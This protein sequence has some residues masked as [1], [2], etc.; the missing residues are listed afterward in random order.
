METTKAKINSDK[1]NK[2]NSISDMKLNRRKEWRLELPLKAVVEGTLPDGEKFI[3][4]TM[5]ENISSTGAYFFLNSIITI[6][7][8]LDLF[9][10][11]PSKMTEGKKLRLYLGGEAVRLE[12]LDEKDKKQGVALRFSEEFKSEEFQ[13]V[14]EKG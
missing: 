10:D 11:L 4:N 6:G 14:S 1:K 9:I 5:L 13:L 12:K 8:K 2:A 7:T 3:E